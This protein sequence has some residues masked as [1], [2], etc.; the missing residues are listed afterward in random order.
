MARKLIEFD[1]DKNGCFNVTSHAK[2]K[3]GYPRIVVNNKGQRIHR[4]MYEQCLGFIPKKMCVIHKCDNPLCINP[5]HLKLG[6]HKDNMVDRNRKRRT[7]FGEKNGQNKLTE[8]QVKIIKKSKGIRPL[9]R[10]FNVNPKT[11][12]DIK[13][14]KNWSYLNP[15]SV[16]DSSKCL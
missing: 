4:F 7:A 5:Y 11:I 13:I 9:A 1:E 3:D 15:C 16:A 10:R 6:T 12:Y 2:D 14:G 8:E